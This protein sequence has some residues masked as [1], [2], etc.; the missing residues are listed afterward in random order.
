MIIEPV[1]S[2]S[3]K[4]SSSLSPIEKEVESSPLLES[5]CR[6]VRVG[7]DEVSMGSAQLTECD[8][9]LLL[10]STRSLLDGPPTS[11]LLSS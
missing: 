5:Q 1:S 9:G 6:E 11:V 3:S 8:D 10:S 4:K 7:R 2:S